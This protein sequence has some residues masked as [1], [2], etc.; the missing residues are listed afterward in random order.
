MF[1]SEIRPCFHSTT[2]LQLIITGM[3]TVYSA[4]A[5]L[6]LGL[7]LHQFGVI[8]NGQYEAGGVVVFPPLP[9]DWVAWAVPRL[10]ACHIYYLIQGQ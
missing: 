6:G 4:V 7:L 5:N 8:N 2:W 3:Y 9:P 1:A 10:H